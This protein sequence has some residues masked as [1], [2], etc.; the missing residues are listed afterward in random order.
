MLV[1]KA[2]TYIEA[3]ELSLVWQHKDVDKLTA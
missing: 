3:A 2:S 1:N